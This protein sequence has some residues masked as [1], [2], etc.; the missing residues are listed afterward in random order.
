MVYLILGNNA[1]VAEQEV[2]K[3]EKMLG[4]PRER[5]DATALDANGLADIMRGGSLFA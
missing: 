4:L 3:L 2:A 1:Y 5:L